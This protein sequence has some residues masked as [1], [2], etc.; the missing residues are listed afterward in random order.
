M[1]L[2]F[3]IPLVRKKV[4]KRKESTSNIWSQKKSKIAPIQRT[5]RRQLNFVLNKTWDPHRQ[6]HL[7][8]KKK[9]TGQLTR[10]NHQRSTWVPRYN[11]ISNIKDVLKSNYNSKSFLKFPYL[12]S[13]LWPIRWNDAL[14]CTFFSSLKHTL[15]V[16]H[17][18]R[19]NWKLWN[20][21]RDESPLMSFFLRPFCE[22]GH[23]KLYKDQ[24]FSLIVV[25]P[26]SLF[27]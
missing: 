10:T 7:K 12:N 21:W 9:H 2:S 5:Q 1:Q 11:W 25:L 13:P 19:C 14:K 8:K 20:W 16:H 24:F 15:T 23:I 4:R 17:W 22:I 27:F 26:L 18:K 6:A 3:Q